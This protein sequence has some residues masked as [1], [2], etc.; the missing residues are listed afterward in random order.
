[1][2]RQKKNGKNR[3][4]KIKSEILKELDECAK[5]TMLSKTVIV[6]KALSDFFTKYKKEN[7]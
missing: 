3:T 1:M 7:V 4:F 6:E 2:A 5:K